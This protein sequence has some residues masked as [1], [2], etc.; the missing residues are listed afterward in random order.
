MN[1]PE[2]AGIGSAYTSKFAAQANARAAIFSTAATDSGFNR[3]TTK[4]F[5]IGTLGYFE[6]L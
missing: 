5:P 1:S 4:Y 2:A 3:S 6:Q